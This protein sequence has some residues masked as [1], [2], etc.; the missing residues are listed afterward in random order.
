MLR[1]Q[2]EVPMKGILR[3]KVDAPM[4][5]ER[6]ELLLCRPILRIELVNVVIRH[7]KRLHIPFRLDNPDVPVSDGMVQQPVTDKVY[8]SVG[9]HA[10]TVFRKKMPDAP[11]AFKIPFGPVIP[12]IAV[13]T[14]LW[15]LAQAKPQQLIMGLGAA[16]IAVP[17]YYFVYKNKK[18]E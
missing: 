14:S 15:L 4:L 10:C 16:V 1:R 18:E 5:E 3:V 17:F 7:V 8:Q 12:V 13:L 9:R 11:R 6:I 2:T